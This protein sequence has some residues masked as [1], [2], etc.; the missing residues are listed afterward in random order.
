MRS[1][2]L[3]S[4]LPPFFFSDGKAQPK[5]QIPEEVIKAANEPLTSGKQS[6]WP[7]SGRRERNLKISRPRSHSRPLSSHPHSLHFFTGP[8]S[9]VVNNA[10]KRWYYEAAVEASKG[11]VVSPTTPVPS[12]ALKA[13]STSRFSLSHSL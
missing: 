8:L 10:V 9:K 12:L 7:L 13:L 11:D 5:L 6:L 2:Q 4:R 3:L 1:H